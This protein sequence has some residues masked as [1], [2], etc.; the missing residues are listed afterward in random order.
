ML[1]D[2]VEINYEKSKEK[3]ETTNSN[4]LTTKPLLNSKDDVLLAH[5]LA[6]IFCS[7]SKMKGG[8]NKVKERLN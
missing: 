4:F 6:I 1:R 2:A 3:N 8:G 7:R 5:I